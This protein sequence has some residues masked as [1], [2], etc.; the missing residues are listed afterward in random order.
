MKNLIKILQAHSIE[1]NIVKDRVIA[2]EHQLSAAGWGINEV[3]VTNYNKQQ[4]SN[5]LGY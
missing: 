1:F 4:L 3:D 5:F 2:Q